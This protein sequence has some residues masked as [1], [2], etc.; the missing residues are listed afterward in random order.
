MHDEL[1]VQGFRGRWFGVMADPNHDAMALV[2]AI[3][4][5]LFLI[6]GRGHRWLL[7]IAGAFGAAACIAGIIATHS[8][9]GSIGLAIAVLMFA[10]LSRRKA[11][12]GM[13]VLAAPA[14]KLLPP[15]AGFLERHKTAGAG[16]QEHLILLRP[17]HADGGDVHIPREP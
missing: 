12:A 15:P 10:L 5:L 13:A 3:P 7:R 8:R 17:Q 16:P 1:L 6:T 4:I 11:L 2:G 14:A 9:G